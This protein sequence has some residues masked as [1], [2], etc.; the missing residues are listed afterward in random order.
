MDGLA[1]SIIHLLVTDDIFMQIKH[2]D[3]SHG[4]WESLCDMHDDPMVVD[5]LHIDLGTD[6]PCARGRSCSCT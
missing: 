5:T 6:T 2:D 1:T 3:T 4:M